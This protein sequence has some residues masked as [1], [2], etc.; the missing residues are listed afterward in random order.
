MTIIREWQTLQCLAR[1]GK[2]KY[3][4]IRVLED[5]GEH[6]IEV[7]WW[8][9]DGAHQRQAKKIIGKNIGRA[10]ET[11][12]LDQALN[13]AKADYLHQQDKGYSI[14]GKSVKALMLPML[15]QDFKSRK[16]T[17]KFPCWCQPKF[18]GVRCLFNPK[19]GF[20]S[21]QGKLFD[22][23][24]LSHLAWNS[25][26]YITLDGELMLP[27][28]YTFQQTVSA[29]KKQSEL[30]PLLEYHVFDAVIEG[31]FDSRRLALKNMEIDLAADKP[32]QLYIVL[33]S[34]LY[35]TQDVES[36]LADYLRDGYEGMILRNIEGEYE[37]GQRSTNLLKYKEF[38]DSEYEIVG[39]E[40]GLGK[41]EGAAIFV[42]KT[43]RGQ[44]FRCRPTGTYDSR[45]VIFQNKEEYIGKW[46]QV[47]YQNATDDGLPRFP[48]GKNIRDMVNGQPAL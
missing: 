17:I 34:G 35:C 39:V 18:D 2:V 19:L 28:P 32:A 12:P 36:V 21:R 9:G 42:C 33:T 41:E 45:R 3:W 26:D 20:W 48:V 15:A 6:L 38:F 25:V 22:N 47:R 43:D 4:Q 13:E 31:T 14:D 11:T 5:G 44:V 40:D 7:E 27:A 8:Q 23:A 24:N 46:L 37:I 10:N 30:T 1:T 16:N 29:V